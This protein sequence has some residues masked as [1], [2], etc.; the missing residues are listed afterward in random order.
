VKRLAN[1][2]PT[3]LVDAVQ[4][5]EAGGPGARVVGGGSDLLGMLK[6]D[7]V[8]A[9]VLVNLKALDGRERLDRV[10]LEAGGVRIGGLVTLSQLSTHALVARQYQVLAEA[11]GSAAT[12]QIRNV[13]TVAGNLCQRPWCWYFRQKFPCHKHGGN[14]CF[15]RSGENEFNA[16]FGGGPSYIVHPS[17]MAPALVALGSTFRLVGPNGARTVPAAEFFTLPRL[18][19]SRENV[20]TSNEVLADITVPAAS[21]LRSTYAKVLDREAW[22]HAVVSVALALEMDGDLIRRAGVVLGGV[23][24]IPWQ[25]PAVQDLLAGRRLTETLAV[26]AGRLA[27]D[28]AQPLSKNG[29]KVQLT[30]T[31]VR[32]TLLSLVA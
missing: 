25:V 6:D 22:T 30:E 9:N 5:L 29:Y 8:S 4:R 13:G 14:R 23:A 1:V 28:R 27:V 15:S 20:L 31:L 2:N 18:D 3:S 11:A 12:P 21:G 17:D 10:D 32:R 7:L 26:Q 24:P 19:V 16:I